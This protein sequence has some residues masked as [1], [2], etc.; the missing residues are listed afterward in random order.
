LAKACIVTLLI[1][2]PDDYD[3]PS[4]ANWDWTALADHTEPI[5]VL[6]TSWRQL[7][8]ARQDDSPSS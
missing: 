1:P 5:S 3:Y 2:I 7:P 4:P 8:S 6:S